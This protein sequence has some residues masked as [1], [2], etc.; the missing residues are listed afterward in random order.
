MSAVNPYSHP[1]KAN[2]PWKDPIVRAK[3]K[4][5][6]IDFPPL[7]QISAEDVQGIII[8]L[9]AYQTEVLTRSHYE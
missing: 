7:E 9:P 3:R 8:A 1:N 6:I 2:H 4:A 5:E